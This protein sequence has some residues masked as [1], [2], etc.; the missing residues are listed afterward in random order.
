MNRIQPH[1][2]KC[3]LL[4]WEAGA[5]LGHVVPLVKLAKQLEQDGIACLVAATELASAGIALQGTGIPLLQAP[6]WPPHL[7]IGNE[8]GQAGYFDILALLGFG[9]TG[10]LTPMMQAWDCLLDLIKPDAVIADHAPA[11]IPLLNARRIP[12]ISVGNGFTLPPLFPTPFPPLSSAKAPTVPE[13]RLFTSLKHALMTLGHATPQNWAT[14]YAPQERLVLSMPE[15]DPYHGVR[16]EPLCLPFERLPSAMSPPSTPRLFVY[17]GA[18]LPGLNAIIQSLSLLDCDVECY[19]RGLP[20]QAHNFL[21]GQGMMVHRTPPDLFERLP[22]ASHVLSQGGTGM[23]HSALAAG[24]PHGIF[25]LHGESRINAQALIGLGAGH[26]F[27][28]GQNTENLLSALKAFIA[29]PQMPKDALRAGKK[30]T[31]RSQTAGIQA[32]HAA[33]HRLLG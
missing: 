27:T 30:I 7:H 21:A 16:Q 28:E 31:R 26:L 11:L 8:D 3:V 14:A 24:R 19:L 12:T 10:K 29:D 2:G 13:A 25:A 20:A 23:A 4:A 9:D 5:N 33:L 22:L 1:S 6:S 18:E 15:L 32:V 17:L